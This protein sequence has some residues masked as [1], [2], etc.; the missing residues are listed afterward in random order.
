[1]EYQSEAQV[2]ALD[3]RCRDA[4]SPASRR[5]V[6][7]LRAMAPATQTLCAA[8][9]ALSDCENLVRCALDGGVSVESR[10]KGMPL[11]CI[12]SRS[13]ALRTQRT[14]L[15]GGADANARSYLGNTAL[16]EAIIEKHYECARALIDVSD[17]AITS[18]DGQNA[19]HVCINTGNEE[20]FDLLLPRVSDV[21][22]RLVQG[23]DE[24]GSPRP[25]FGE[26]ALMMACARGQHSMAKALLVRGASRMATNSGGWTPAICAVVKGHLSCLVLVLG[27]KG[28][29]KLRPEQVNAADNLGAKALH[30]AAAGGHTKCCGVLIDAGARLDA[31]PSGDINITPLILAQRKHPGNADLLRMLSGHGA[32]AQA[33]GTGC[34]RCGATDVPLKSCT[35]CWSARFCS[36]AC[37]QAHWP[38]HKT[39]C[40]RKAAERE[41]G[42]QTRI[43]P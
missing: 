41:A 14:L 1:M 24:H 5:A 27:K 39:E 11:L 38:T 8:K 36:L 30:Y 29:Y 25:I 35:G 32:S 9:Y 7:E 37:A 18:L 10:F 42:V 4:A 16:M 3:A 13:G 19:L 33:S 43:V 40:Q 15:A 22:V 20:C 12:A 21:D 2:R 28:N 23:V 6:R 34:E 31:T 17:L 26:T